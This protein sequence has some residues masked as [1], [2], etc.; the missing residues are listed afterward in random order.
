MGVFIQSINTVLVTVISGVAVFIIG[1]ILQVTWL[2][3]LQKYKKIKSEVVWALMYYANIYSCVIVWPDAD[4]LIQEKY[5][6]AKDKMRIISCEV[7]GFAETMYWFH[8]GIPS[9]RR[10]IR[11][12]DNLMY[13]SN[14][15]YMMNESRVKEMREKR[16]VEIAEKVYLELK[17]HRKS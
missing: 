12:A 15:L 6:E 9:K 10:L 14:S 17:I 16:N 5:K 13:L 4:T 7:N 8:L 3:P 11:A 1:E 2:E